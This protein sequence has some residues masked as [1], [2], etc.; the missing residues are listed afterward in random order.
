MKVNDYDSFGAAYSA[1]NEVNLVNGHYERPAMLD[2][3]GDVRGRRVLDAGCGSGPLAAA[4]RARGAV[5]T[6]FDSSAVMVA[7]ARERLGE[8]ADAH[9]ADLSAPFP[10]PTAAATT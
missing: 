4:L 5:V 7:L 1:D 8:D 6:G 2:L 3:L 10:S 9:V